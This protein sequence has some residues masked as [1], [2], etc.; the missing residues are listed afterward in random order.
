LMPM[1]AVDGRRPWGWWAVEAG[2]LRYPGRDLERSTLFDAGLLDA[3]EEAELLMD[4]RREFDRAHG[5]DFFYCAGLRKFLRGAAARHEHFR[6]ADI[7]PALV[8]EWSAEH[9]ARA[10]LD[11][12]DQTTATAGREAGA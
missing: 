2:D 12:R 4:W 11:G 8:E 10:S 1:L 7:P 9:S 5:P 6:W 3:E